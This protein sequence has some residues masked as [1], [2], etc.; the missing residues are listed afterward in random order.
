MSLKVS[1]Y[2]HFFQADD[3]FELAYNALTNSFASVAEPE[4]TLIKKILNDPN[5][6]SFDSKEKEQLKDDL[7]KGGFLVEEEF[8]ELAFLKMRNR[9][10]RFTTDYFGLTIAPTLECNFNCEYCF[11]KP[12]Q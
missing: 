12:R 8:D 10:G 2:N 5:A 9:I 3:G 4:N 7:I 11:E 6:F 1:R